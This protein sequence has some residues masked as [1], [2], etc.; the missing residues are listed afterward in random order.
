M[1]A[2]ELGYPD[3]ERRY[4]ALELSLK[5][6]FA[7]NW[8]LQ[9]SYTWSHLYGNSE[10]WVNSEIGASTAGLTQGFDHPGLLDHAD[11]NLPQDRRH[12]LKLLGSY[13][14]DSGLQLGAVASYRS[15]RPINSL[16]YHPTDPAA[17]AYGQMSFYTDGEPSP[18]GSAGTT[19]SVVN[20]DLMLAYQGRLRHLQWTA[21]LDVFNLLDADAVTEVREF[22]EAYPGVADPYWGRATAH[23]PARKVRLGVGFEF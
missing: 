5:R 18:R 11:G 23:Q 4:L 10:G 19:D 2:E 1:T 6:R 12:N 8:M 17:A 21:R 15:G 20:L 22:A 9:G 7:D 14:F 13:A 3:A 16:G